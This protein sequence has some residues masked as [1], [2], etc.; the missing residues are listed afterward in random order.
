MDNE[1]LREVLTLPERDGL[2]LE[3]NDELGDTDKEL[4]CDTDKLVDTEVDGD[5]DGLKDNE[6]DILELGDDDCDPLKDPLSLTLSD[7]LTEPDCEDEEAKQHKKSAGGSWAELT[8]HPQRW[9]PNDN[10]CGL[11]CSR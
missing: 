6:L 5:T 3:D 9:S 11:R 1:E 4:D 10:G 8:P 7:E 2:E